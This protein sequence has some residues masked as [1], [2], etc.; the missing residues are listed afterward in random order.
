MHGVDHDGV[1]NTETEPG[2]HEDRRVSVV[3][4]ANHPAGPRPAA[5]RYIAVMDVNEFLARPL[6]ARVATVGPSVRPVWFIWEEGAFWWLTGAYSRLEQIIA[7]DPR[8]ALVVDTCV[9]PREVFSVTCRGSAETVALD[10]A[11]A[12]RKLG[13][14]LGPLELW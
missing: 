7:E 13:K 10:R 11:R 14:Y 3:G 4:V 9:R 12:V 6:V 1:M 5:R 2:E 8:M